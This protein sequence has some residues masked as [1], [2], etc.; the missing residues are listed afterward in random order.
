V[1]ISREPEPGCNRVPVAEQT[2]PF[3]CHTL[4]K[5][6]SSESLVSRV[7]AMAAQR[8][9]PLQEAS[10]ASHT[11]W[12][13][14]PGD[15]ESLRST[16]AWIPPV[17]AG[18]PEGGV[19]CTSPLLA[20]GPGSDPGRPGGVQK[21]PGRFKLRASH[22]GACQGPTVTVP[23]TVRQ[24]A[25]AVGQRDHWATRAVAQHLTSATDPLI[26]RKPRAR[27]PPQ[28]PAGPGRGPVSSGNGGRA[29]GRR[30]AHDR[31]LEAHCQ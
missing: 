19:C 2:A 3:S 4:I 25:S 15:S 17:Q 8:R 31:A 28:P 11:G 30:R 12:G 1:S 26:N 27:F 29:P 22:D 18:R 9:W 24:R 6:P 10:R 16:A 20:W 23:V 21:R 5:L 13:F 14:S 7:L